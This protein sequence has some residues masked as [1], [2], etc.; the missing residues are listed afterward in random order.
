MRTRSLIAVGLSL[1]ALALSVGPASALSNE[2]IRKA[3]RSYQLLGVYGTPRISALAFSPDGARLYAAGTDDLLRVFDAT[4]LSLLASYDHR[5]AWASHVAVSPDGGRIAVG[6]ADGTVTVRDAN[7]GQVTGRFAGAGRP[8]I[9]L[10]WGKTDSQLAVAFLHG[11][12]RVIDVLSS[13]PLET[14]GG[15]GEWFGRVDFHVELGLAVSAGKGGDIRIWELSGGRMRAHIPVGDVFHTE[16]ELSPGGTMVTAAEADGALR[17]FDIVSGEQLCSAPGLARGG[18][19]YARDGQTIFR[20][21]ATGEP[22]R[23]VVKDCSV[24]ETLAAPPRWTGLPLEINDEEEAKARGEVRAHRARI[25]AGSNAA[26]SPNGDWMAESWGDT[27][28]IWELSTGRV[29]ASRDTGLAAVTSV[30]F[31]PTEPLLAIA[32]RT[33]AVRVREPEQGGA[34]R[35]VLVLPKGPADAISF[36]ANGRWLAVAGPDDHVRAWEVLAGSVAR[37]LFGH[38][39]PVTDVAFAPQGLDLY[40]ASAD[41]TLAVWDIETRQRTRTIEGPGQP[42]R[43]I[44]VSPDG[45]RLAVWS[46]PPPK[47][48]DEPP[49]PAALKG[50]RLY[51]VG[52]GLLTTVELPHAGG[53]GA[54]TP[55]GKLLFTSLDSLVALTGDGKREEGR[56]A[57]RYAE[58]DFTPDGAL[59]AGASREGSVD[60]VD[61]RTGALVTSLA[62]HT[63]RV[64]AVAFSADGRMVASGS[65][66]GTV[67]VWARP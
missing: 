31:S 66:D 61:P 39:A 47:D 42:L 53:A 51:G 1:V 59:M 19:V 27:L 58:L 46:A 30:A 21:T 29:L 13:R 2:E 25:Y 49:S 45:G 14:M 28:R 65:E 4:D 5:G 6:D 11:P 12:I 60:L 52:G 20:P 48:G 24:R 40:S 55:D 37:T 26:L 34:V 8:V 38:E 54:W 67:R 62:G 10:A 9:G 36:S 3:A 22:Q 23:M 64:N 18:L 33:G 7:T 17:V 43:R 16:L 41:G 35:A 50:P 15:P 56:G 57:G 63:G 32:D 44:T